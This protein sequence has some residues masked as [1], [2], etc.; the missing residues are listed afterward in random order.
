M[1]IPELKMGSYVRVDLTNF[2]KSSKIVIRTGEISK[3][4]ED[5]TY[6]IKIGSFVYP[7]CDSENFAIYNFSLEPLMI[8]MNVET[9]TGKRGKLLKK[10]APSLCFDIQLDGLKVLK[11]VHYDFFTPIYQTFA[12]GEK[13]WYKRVDKHGV[14]KAQIS[15]LIYEVK[16]ENNVLEKIPEFELVPRTEFAKSALLKWLRT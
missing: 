3:V 13:V 16:L 10:A 8:G 7:S 6:D 4:N 12:I 15:D 2:S 1:L 14:V 9:S 11:E 5:G